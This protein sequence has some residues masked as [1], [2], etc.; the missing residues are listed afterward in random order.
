M[1]G[2]ELA[3]RLL[4]LP[5]RPVV[6]GLGRS[7]Y[8]EPVINTE[9][10]TATM[11]AAG[12]EEVIELSLGESSTHEIKSIVGVAP[13]RQLGGQAH[14]AEVVKGLLTWYAVEY[15]LAAMRNELLSRNHLGAAEKVNDALFAVC[16]KLPGYRRQIAD[17]EQS[18]KIAD[19]MTFEPKW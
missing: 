5:D 12:E 15:V 17:L 11:M 10:M 19:I 1:T 9:V 3:Q 14:L 7:G 8:G 16:R 18:G 2:H 6:T 4:K 13:S